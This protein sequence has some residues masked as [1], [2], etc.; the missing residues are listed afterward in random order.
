MTLEDSIYM[1]EGSPRKTEQI[2]VTSAIDGASPQV[3]WSFKRL[4]AL[5]GGL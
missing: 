1:G 3:K 5:K 2:V 4:E